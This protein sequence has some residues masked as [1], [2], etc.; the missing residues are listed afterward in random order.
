MK[1]HFI[2][3]VVLITTLCS[4]VKHTEISY[5]SL[6]DSI[7]MAYEVDNKELSEN[8]Q[9]MFHFTTS[10]YLKIL[11]KNPDNNVFESKYS[12]FYSEVKNDALIIDGY[13]LSSYE[14]RD[15]VLYYKKLDSSKN[16]IELRLQ[17][18]P[19]SDFIN[20]KMKKLEKFT[21]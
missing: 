12:F 20:I 7:W 18:T 15:A 2:I 4:C 16:K 8:E 11:F 10:E 5:E 3:F 21:Y 19:D 17:L 13:Y 9:F 1:K 6:T 14:F